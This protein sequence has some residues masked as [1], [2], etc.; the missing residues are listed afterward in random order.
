MII[1]VMN[2]M[3]L[4]PEYISVSQ[5]SDDIL[6]YMQDRFHQLMQEERLEDA[7]AIGDEYLEWISQDPSEVYLYYLEHELN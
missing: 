4:N 5:Q 3:S 6:S 2:S 7:I 1:S